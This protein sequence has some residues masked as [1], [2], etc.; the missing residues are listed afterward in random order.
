MGRQGCYSAS[1]RRC[2]KRKR[3]RWW[4]T[5]HLRL[6]A[7]GALATLYRQ[8]FVSRPATLTLVSCAWSLSLGAGNDELDD[9]KQL[10]Q[11][12]A[13]VDEVEILEE[14]DEDRLAA[15]RAAELKERADKLE[16]AVKDRLR[17]V[18]EASHLDHSPLDSTERIEEL[19]TK[20]DKQEHE[21]R[22]IT[23]TMFDPKANKKRLKQQEKQHAKVRPRSG[24]LQVL[25]VAISCQ[26][27]PACPRLVTR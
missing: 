27:D 12:G 2:P 1:G 17:M 9:L 22:V 21:M 6:A 24:I 26:C 8:Q 5:C 16:Q 3:C 4:W 7:F 13:L 11:L 10:E 15:E 23:D 25:P 19:K 14:E 18:A 20:I